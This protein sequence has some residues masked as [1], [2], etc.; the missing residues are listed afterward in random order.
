MNIDRLA[1]IL[2]QAAQQEILPRFRRLDDGMIKTKTGAFDLVTEAD[3]NA[4]RVITAAILAHSPN[5]LVIGEEAVSANPALLTSSLEDRITIYVDPVDGTANFAGGLPL[6]AVMAA[7]VQNGEPVAGVIYD[8]MGDD[9]LM[10]EKGCGTWQVFPDGRRIRMKFADPVPLA[11]MGGLASTG[12]LPLEQRRIV[13]GNLAKIKMLG[14]Y[15]CAGHEYRFAAGG[16]IH[17]LMYNKLM[18]WDHVAGALMM[19]EC[20]AHVAKFD[21]SDYRPSDTGGGLLIAPDKDSWDEIKREVF[22]V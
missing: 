6:F 21:G 7:V 20:G 14:N 19:R 11:E 1:A 13:L 5:T 15:R 8:P 2:K 17:F 10:A 9:F 3:T 12:F 16:N 18:P 4:E 22:T